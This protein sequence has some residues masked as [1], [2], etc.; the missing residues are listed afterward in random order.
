MN[1]KANDINELASAS[2]ELSA[3]LS[4]GI[5]VEPSETLAISEPQ[6]K[7]LKN[8][9]GKRK[10]GRPRHLIL[11]TTQLEVYKLSRVGTRHEDIAIL[12]G[13]SEDTLAKYY[14]KELDKG[15]I[16]AN[17]AIAGTLYEK[18]KQGDTASMLFWLK[19][20]AGWHEKHTTE[21]TGE[22]GNPINI[23]VITGID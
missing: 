20:R 17:A 16:E 7:C 13:F 14:R 9:Q 8:E 6:E 21:L 2:I 10:R 3:E 12:L 22:G 11:A 15:R 19:T 4:T 5:E 18:A 23:K 1:K